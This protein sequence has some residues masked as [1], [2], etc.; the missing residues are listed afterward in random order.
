MFKQ[1]KS[2]KAALSKFGSKVE[3]SKGIG[4]VCWDGRL[5][6]FQHVLNESM[7]ELSTLFKWMQS[8]RPDVR[9]MLIITDNCCHLRTFWEGIFGKDIRLKRDPAHLSYL[10]FKSF[11]K[12]YE[13]SSFKQM[14]KNE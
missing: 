5:L 4:T 2:N 12:D 3:L 7:N 9:D 11:Q 13:D 10:I 6:H 14:V 1:S 8:L